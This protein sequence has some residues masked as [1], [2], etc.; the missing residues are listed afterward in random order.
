MT[1]DNDSDKRQTRTPVREGTAQRQDRDCGHFGRERNRHIHTSLI[2]LQAKL[3]IFIADA[4]EM[5]VLL[6]REY[7]SLASISS[8]VGGG[9]GGGGQHAGC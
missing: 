8:L 2:A 9:V 1:A 5:S 3:P 7:S 6:P 4:E